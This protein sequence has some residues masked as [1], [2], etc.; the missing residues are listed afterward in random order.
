MFPLGN[1]TPSGTDMPFFKI[2]H[3][4][5]ERKQVRQFWEDMRKQAE[6]ILDEYN[7]VSE[8]EFHK[9]FYGNIIFEKEDFMNRP[10]FFE[11]LSRFQCR[12][13]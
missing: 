11:P 2:A 13:M 10:D 12:E 6:N 8:N 4:Y 1:K 5:A 9:N 3:T 7:K